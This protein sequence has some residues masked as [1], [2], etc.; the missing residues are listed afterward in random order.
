MVVCGDL[1]PDVQGAFGINVMWRGIYLN[2]S[3][4]YAYGGQAT[5]TRWYR[6]WRTPI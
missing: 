1:N 5:T 6:K 4:Q 2:T 3:F